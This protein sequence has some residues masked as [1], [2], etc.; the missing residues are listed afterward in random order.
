MVR[1]KKSEH[2]NLIAEQTQIEQVVETQFGQ[3]TAQQK[4][5]RNEERL[6]VIGVDPGLANMGIAVV[7]QKIADYDVG[8]H[9]CIKTS[10]KEQDPARLLKLGTAFKE[11]LERHTP[12][13]VSIETIF[14]SRNKSSALKVA[15]VIG[16]L[17]YISAAHGTPCFELRPNAI[18]GII[19]AE[20]AGKAAVKG[21]IEA[22]TGEGFKTDH[23]T[24]AVAIAIAYI[25][26]RSKSF[27]IL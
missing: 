3:Q 27:L 4:D 5:D 13:A 24:D 17:K 7:T 15:G 21:R 26:G 19:G 8:Y 16:M 10:S 11:T 14:F 23:E 2:P 20:G 9:A 6:K 1:Y 22:L 25:L 12:D 18:K